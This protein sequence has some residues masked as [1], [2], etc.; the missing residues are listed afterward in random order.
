MEQKGKIE[1]ELRTSLNSQIS[2]PAVEAQEMAN[3]H[4]E[5]RQPSINYPE[6]EEVHPIPET[7]TRGKQKND[8]AKRGKL[9]CLAVLILS[10][11]LAIYIF[12][13]K[14]PVANGIQ[15]KYVIADRLNTYL[16][17]SFV[18]QDPDVHIKALKIVSFS[19]ENIDRYPNF[20]D[21]AYVT[22]QIGKL[23]I[24]KAGASSAWEYFRKS[25]TTI[26]KMNLKT[27]T[28]CKV[29]YYLASTLR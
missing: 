4:V 27:D 16:K 23:T 10:L 6:F 22:Y 20:N 12:I 3:P 7:S 29:T 19:I 13:S 1:D 24:R 21:L 8:K 26:K 18:S 25:Y 2:E 5:Q 15:N 11:S 17:D 14:R 28:E 9:P